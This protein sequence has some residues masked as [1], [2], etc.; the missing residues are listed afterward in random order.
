MAMQQAAEAIA[1]HGPFADLA[2]YDNGAT[3][4]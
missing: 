1:H 2:T 3:P 4:G